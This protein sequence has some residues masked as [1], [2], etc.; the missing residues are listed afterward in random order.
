MLYRSPDLNLIDQGILDE[1]VAMRAELSSTLRTP[2][3]WT[4][5]LRRTA[6]A[7]AIRGSNSIEGINVDLD[8]ADASLDGDEPLSAQERTYAEITGYR[9]ALGYV[10]AMADDPHFTVDVAAIRSMHFM[11]L[12]HDLTKSPGQYRHSEI[13]VQDEN[14]GELVYTGPDPDRL[15]QLM[16]ALTTSLN[17]D[18]RE[19]PPEVAAAMAHL[20]LVMI[21]PFR[22]GNG[23][24][25]RALQTLVLARAGVSHPE[26]SSLEE[27][28]GANTDDYYAV[29]A[30]TGE[31]TWAP[32]NDAGLWVSFA[33]RA[34]HIQAQTVR[35][36]FERAST[37]YAALDQLVGSHRLPERVVDSLYMA[38]LGYR[39]R[40]GP[41]ARQA[42]LDDRTASRDLAALVDAGV[43][44]PR[45]QT[46]GRHYVMGPVLRDLRMREG[47]RPAVVD[48]NPELRA[49]IAPHRRVS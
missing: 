49:R 32:Q 24:M 3:R 42:S 36:R 15:P 48:P 2:R 35:A 9:Q 23:R 8:D 41:Y 30:A 43:L 38:L 26:F 44:E 6:L 18:L 4:G 19:Q 45:G 20:N 21:H 40:R 34:H 14:S 28:L 46:R 33:L 12:S 11:M 17:D 5:T 1:V 7:R 29:L 25:A 22:D 47:M 16:Q 37:T 13:Y 39:L 27:W 31:G 10:L